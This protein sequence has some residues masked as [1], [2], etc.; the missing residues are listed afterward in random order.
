MRKTFDEV[1]VG[2]FSVVYKEDGG[3]MSVGSIISIDTISDSQHFMIKRKFITIDWK[4]NAGRLFSYIKTQTES[5]EFYDSEKDILALN[6][7]LS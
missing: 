1:K 4:I 7:K 2:D 3:I 6:L 5:Y